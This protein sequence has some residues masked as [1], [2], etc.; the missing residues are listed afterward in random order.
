MWLLHVPPS[1][2][3]I[4]IPL[5]LVHLIYAAG[6][7]CMCQN[8]CSKLFTFVMN[9]VLSSS[10]GSTLTVKFVLLNGICSAQLLCPFVILLLFWSTK[11]D[12]AEP[13]HRHWLLVFMLSLCG[14]YICVGVRVSDFSKTTRPRDMLF[15]PYLLRMKICSRHADLFVHLFPRAVRREVPPFKVWKV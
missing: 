15:L 12:N 11:S 13:I 3:K 7:N 1:H 14:V 8:A 6:D 9:Q 5:S 10:L 2:K 4:Y